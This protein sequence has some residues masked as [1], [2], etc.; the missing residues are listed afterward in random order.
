MRIWRLCKKRYAATA[1]AGEGARLY[2][3]RWNPPGIAMV[4]TSPSL[5]LASIELFV[6]IDP[7]L[8]PTDLVYTAADIPEGLRVERVPLA[9]LPS[10]WRAIDHPALKT[11]GAEWITSGRSVALEVPSAAVQGEWNVLL[12]PDHAEFAAIVMDPP[13]PWKF[14]DRMFRHR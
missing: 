14:D 7:S 1:F 4:Y 2:G 8:A 9:S 5:A 11:I 3:G 12:N 10:D 6:H 13:E